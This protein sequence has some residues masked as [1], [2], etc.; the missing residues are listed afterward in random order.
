[1]TSLRDS[2]NYEVGPRPCERLI[3]FIRNMSLGTMH[4]P[5]L[6]YVL[7]L[8]VSYKHCGFISPPSVAVN[9][10]FCLRMGPETYMQP[11]DNEVSLINL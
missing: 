8:C 1:M 3:Q 10:V 5:R 9:M 11:S 7:S 2:E 4:G 6:P